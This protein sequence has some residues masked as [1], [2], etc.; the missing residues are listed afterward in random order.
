MRL[1][2]VRLRHKKKGIVITVNEHEWARDLGR[3]KWSAFERVGERHNGAAESL[4]VSAPEP[5]LISPADV[6]ESLPE[7]AEESTPPRR[8]GRPRKYSV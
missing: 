2:T 5:A 4:E 6:D 7:T 3:Y 1:P 8:R